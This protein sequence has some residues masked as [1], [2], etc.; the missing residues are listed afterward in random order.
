VEHAGA[1]LSAADYD[2]DGRPDLLLLDGVESRLYRNRGVADNGLPHFEDTTAAAG[3]EGIGEA[4][5]ALFADLDNDG[6]RDLFIARYLASNRLFRGR[7]D[8]S[9]E[10]ASAN[11]GLDDTLPA[12]SATALDFDRDGLLD[13][14]VAAYGNAFETFPRLPFFARNGAPNRLYRNLGNLR[15]EE[16][17]TRS[18]TGDTGW[19]LAVTAGDVNDDGWPDLAVANDFGRKNLYRNEGDGTFTEIAREAGVLDFS[20]GMGVAFGDFDNDGL[21]D[22]YTSNI[23]S[24]QRWFGED[25]TAEQYLR[26]VLRSRWLWKDWEEFR[27]LHGLIGSDWI[28]LGRQVGEG[29]SLFRNRGDGTFEELKESE[30]NRAGWSWGVAFADLDGDTDLDLFAANGWISRTRGTDL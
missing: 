29:N 7:G 14:Y 28:H 4:H 30:A 5:S 25:R 23:N 18:G 15:F 6:H 19:S 11:S 17:T 2:G 8:G 20:G 22:L 1:G 24:N 27:A 12:T 16:V 9:F 26:N 3:L 21:P 10:E 13:L